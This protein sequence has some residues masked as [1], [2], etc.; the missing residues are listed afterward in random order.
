MMAKK[1]G[2]FFSGFG[3]QYV[4]AAKDIYDSSR[5]VQEY[6]EEAYNCLG[7]NFVKLCFASSEEDLTHLDNAYLAVFLTDIAAWSLLGELGVEPAVIAGLDA[8]MY[9]GLFVAGGFSFPDALYLLNKY[10]GFYQEFLATNEL[11][12]WRVT[13]LKQRVLNDLLGAVQANME[14][15]VINTH[16][17]FLIGG[18][19]L[20][21]EKLRKE[22]MTLMLDNNK[23][24]YK[25]VPVALGL[26]SSILAEPIANKFKI[27]LEK[28]DFKDLRFPVLNSVTG[29]A[30]L[31]GKV[32]KKDLVSQIIQP[33][34]W[35]KIITGFQDCDL[36][37]EVGAGKK[38]AALLQQV[39]P[40]KEILTLGSM[41]DLVQVQ[42]ALGL[43]NTFNIEDIYDSE[44]E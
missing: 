19:E 44:P 3:S 2:V 23:I 25:E 34:N 29:K 36:I 42:V 9:S 6:F 40:D 41:A 37:I 10:L 43:T 4:G 24:D 14:I 1:L 33:I 39:Y 8:G 26:N 32:L 31:T 5:V 16:S 27:Y 11:K 13:G 22:V 35:P 20:E 18:S 7:I 30:I 28:V 21:F 17:D 15:T 38:L 12:L